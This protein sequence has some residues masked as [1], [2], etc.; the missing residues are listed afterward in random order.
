MNKHK[1]TETHSQIQR[2]NCWLPEERGGVLGKIDKGDSK[3]QPLSY[4][5]NKSWG[6]NIQHKEY[7]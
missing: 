3:V 1:E 2:T 4:K 6:Y 7:S 5:A